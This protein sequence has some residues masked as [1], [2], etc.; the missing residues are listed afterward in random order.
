MR[1]QYGKVLSIAVAVLF[2]C[3]AFN[4]TVSME[5][6][7]EFINS[8][9]VPWGPDFIPLDS[10]WDS[11]GTHC[12]VVGNDTSG[13]QSSVWYYN[14]L[15]DT[16][17]Q[18]S[19][20]GDPSILAPYHI[21]NANTSIT[22]PTIQ[23]AINNA[24]AG[25]VIRIWPGTYTEHVIID[26]PLTLRGNNSANT[27][28]DGNGTGDV[29]KIE[30]DEVCIRN[31]GVTGSGGGEAG[32]LLYEVD[33]C[34]IENNSVYSN[35]VGIR[36]EGSSNNLIVNNDIHGNSEGMNVT[37]SAETKTLM[38]VTEDGR[39]NYGSMYEIDPSGSNYDSIYDFFPGSLDG[40]R[41]DE[42]FRLIQD[43]SDPN[44][45][46]GSA[47]YGGRYNAGIVFRVNLDGSGYSVLHDF[48]GGAEDGTHPTGTLLQSGSW[49]YGVCRAGGTNASGIDHGVIFKVAIIN[50]QIN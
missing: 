24:S 25:N 23:T 18:V 12:I 45:L 36:L 14:E 29:I 9:S 3:M 7:A 11:S 42:N 33:N 15:S 47:L 48:M 31:M 17:Y 4:I 6:D 20:G 43:S 10:A 13:I 49:L 1:K 27:I 26:K 19:E 41:P 35:N 2:I 32:I 38:G 39:Y 16:W 34:R 5:A 37:A 50:C 22:Y 8:R 40:S 28:I 21:E 46:Y 30:A 44:I